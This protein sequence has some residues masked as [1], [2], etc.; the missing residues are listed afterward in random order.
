MNILTTE[1]LKKI[2]ETPSG[3]IYALDGVSVSVSEGE[4][5]AVVGS[6]GSG[7]TTF[8]NMIGGLDR[9]TAGQVQIRSKPLGSLSSEELT[10]FRRRN[11]GFV[12]QNYNL[13]PYLN[14]LENITLPLRLDGVSA[15]E[16]FIAEII[17]SLGLEDKTCNMPYMLSGGQQQRVA[18]ARALSTKPAI[19]LADEPTG[20]LD[21]ITGMEVIGLLKTCAVKYHQTIVVV[22]HN[23]EIAQMADRIIR[24][25][26]G[27]VTG[28]ADEK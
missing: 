23:E 11:I 16:P 7:K 25:E 22:T 28:G 6:S 15:D 24:I 19:I 21:S 3:K 8:L 13:L 10:V 9:P 14:V 5:I 1:N 18:I 4:F 17:K 27:K 12:F 20:N 2:Y 26:D